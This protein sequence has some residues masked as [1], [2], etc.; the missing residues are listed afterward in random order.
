ME[1]QPIIIDDNEMA[2]FIQSKVELSKEQIFAVLD[3]E[4][5]F[6]KLKGVIE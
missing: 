2:E 5:D 4:M 3:A 6:L 1:Q